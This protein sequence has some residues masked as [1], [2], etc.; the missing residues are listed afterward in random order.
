MSI[1]ASAVAQ[2]SLRA[3]EPPP[4]ARRHARLVQAYE[5]MFWNT[6]AEGVEAAG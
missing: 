2:A 3:G 5:L 6:L 4:S 1:V